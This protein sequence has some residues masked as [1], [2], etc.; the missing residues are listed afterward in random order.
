[1]KMY[2]HILL[3]TDLDAENA[4]EVP[5]KA[6]A[7]ADVF[8][9]KLSLLHVVESI[10]N[11]G[12]IGIS[13][14]ENKL[15]EEAKEHLAILGKTIQVAEEDQ[16][17]V[18]GSAKREILAAAAELKVD[19]IIIGSHSGMHLSDILGSTTNVVLHH[20]NC[21]VLTIRHAKVS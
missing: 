21:D 17:I 13:E 1:M 11:Y 16:W 7:L 20:A 19:L 10:P 6:R 8:G 5:Q 18:M 15:I 12:F 2:N 4:N 14:L 3:A 9:A